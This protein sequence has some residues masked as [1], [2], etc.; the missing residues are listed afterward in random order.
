MLVPES[1]LFNVIVSP[2]GDFRVV[3]NRVVFDPNSAEGSR[4]C[5]TFISQEDEIMETNEI[6]RFVPVAS[7]AH[8]AFIDGDRASF[9]IIIMDGKAT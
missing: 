8:D 4:R 5:F 9:S 6:F 2:L 7:N 1:N 3:E